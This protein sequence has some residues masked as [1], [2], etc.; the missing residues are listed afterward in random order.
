MECSILISLIQRVMEAALK[1]RSPIRIPS[2]ENSINPVVII[3]S[4]DTTANPA[5]SST[6]TRINAVSDMN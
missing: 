5:N 1:R 4:I 6:K 3:P 2:I